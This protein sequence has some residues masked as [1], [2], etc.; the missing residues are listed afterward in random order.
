MRRLELA[1]LPTP[2]QRPPRLSE[3]LG[4]DLWVKRDDMTGGAESGNKIRKLEYLLAEA[5]ALSADTVV[6][7]GGLQSNHARA[8]AI[9]AASLGMR[10][11]LFLRTTEQS[12]DPASAPLS[13]NVLLDKLAGAELTLI[14]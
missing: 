1:H 7:C 3:A 12:L 11:R 9:C 2:L 8:T 13:G 6:T 14:T 4:V 5:E 10:A